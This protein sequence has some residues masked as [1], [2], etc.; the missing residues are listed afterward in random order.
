VAAVPA[1]PPR[2]IAGPAAAP[3]YALARIGLPDGLGG[4]KAIYDRD[5]VIR[6]AG[7][8]RGRIFL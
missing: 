4:G 1:I 3:Q 5:G 7:G 2:I 6:A 8:A